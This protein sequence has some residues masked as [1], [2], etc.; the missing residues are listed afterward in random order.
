MLLFNYS[1]MPFLPI[2]PPHPSWTHLPP[3]PP[4]SRLVLSMLFTV[5]T[6]Y[7]RSQEF[8]DGNLYLSNISLFPP[9]F[10]CWQLPSYSLFLW[11]QIFRFQHKVRTYTICLSLSYLSNL[12]L[13]PQISS[14]LQQEAWFP[15]FYIWMIVYCV[16]VWVCV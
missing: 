13:R 3:P 14:L 16:Y 10:G 6:H 8:I 11:N 12:V 2:P 15:P 7:I 9:F 4:P 1:C 5:I